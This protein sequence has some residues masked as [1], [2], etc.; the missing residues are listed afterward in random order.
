MIDTNTLLLCDQTFFAA[1]F[2]RGTHYYFRKN[3][4]VFQCVSLG[5]GRFD[6]YDDEIFVVIFPFWTVRLSRI[7]AWPSFE[8]AF[9]N[10]ELFKHGLINWPNYGINI[11]NE[12]YSYSG[13]E[14]FSEI[15]EP[16]DI[17]APVLIPYV[18]DKLI[19]FLDPIVDEDSFKNSMI[20]LNRHCRVFEEIILQE[21]LKTSSIEPARKWLNEMT[22]IDLESERAIAEAFFNSNTSDYLEQ[23]G[24]RSFEDVYNE[25]KDAVK[26]TKKTFFGKL[27]EAVETG[28]YQWI[29]QFITI[30]KKESN[31]F[32]E[33]FFSIRF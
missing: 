3:G 32:F 26:I 2:R 11:S 8:K 25:V 9:T 27:I 33:N 24:F 18:Q 30:E 5:R 29:E 20:R 22:A 28:D 15:G 14:R 10:Q 4:C 12:V 17:V 7:E 6:C 1:G 13:S 31:A 16:Q 19:P 23:Y 21:C